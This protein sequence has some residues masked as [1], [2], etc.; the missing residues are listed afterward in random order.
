MCALLGLCVDA[1]VQT[2]AELLRQGLLEFLDA[3]LKIGGRD[4]VAQCGF[5]P[6]DLNARVVF[7]EAGPQNQIP[8]HELP[9]ERPRLFIIFGNVCHGARPVAVMLLVLLR[10]SGHARAV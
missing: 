9:T 10:A 3:L 1:P 2:I 6:C 7:G 8:L 5:V 4:L